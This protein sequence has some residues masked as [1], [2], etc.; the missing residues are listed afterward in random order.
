MKNEVS[1]FKV[2]KH[3]FFFERS[4]LPETAT[5]KVRKDRL[6]DQL[7]LRVT[8]GEGKGASR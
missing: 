4:E 5:G 1:A 3:V 8:E 2:P 7:A 6:R